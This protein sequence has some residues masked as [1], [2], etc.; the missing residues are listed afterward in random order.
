MRILVTS[1][2]VLEFKMDLPCA[3]VAS[4]AFLDRLLDLRRMADVATC[5]WN[6]PVPPPGSLYVVRNA[7][8]TLYTVF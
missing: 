5:A 7:C 8:V 1:E 4:A 2:A 6:C 3:Q